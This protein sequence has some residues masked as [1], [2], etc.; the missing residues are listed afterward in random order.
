MAGKS[1]RRDSIERLEPR[2]TLSLTPAGA[3]TPVLSQP[4]GTVYS[5]GI[6]AARISSMGL[7]S[8]PV[9][10]GDGS[11]AVVSIDDTGGFFVAFF[12]GN[13]LLVRSFDSQAQPRGPQIEK[14]LGQSDL[15]GQF[16]EGLRIAA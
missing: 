15:A 3:P 11:D 7:P 16:Q 5:P 4:E 12:G 10:V 2:V 9:R 6:Y 13:G 8:D 1:V 14:T